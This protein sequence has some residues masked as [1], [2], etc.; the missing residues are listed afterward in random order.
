[1]HGDGPM[2][3]RDGHEDIAS[4]TERVLAVAE[5]GLRPADQ[6][7][8]AVRRWLLPV[9]FEEGIRAMRHK[10]VSIQRSGLSS[11]TQQS[12]GQRLREQ[13]TVERSLPAQLA[14]LLKEFEQPDNEPEAF[15]RARYAR[16]A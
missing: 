6:L 15:A 5:R 7:D 3:E 11:D 1:M 12:I 9:L 2:L 8:R 10:E 16:A 14:N 4:A 13:Y